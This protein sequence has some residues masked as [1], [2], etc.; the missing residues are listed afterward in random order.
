MLSHVAA[1]VIDEKCASHCAA[2]NWSKD[3]W[4]NT[5]AHVAGLS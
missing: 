5:H 1:I 4:W 2:V 3:F